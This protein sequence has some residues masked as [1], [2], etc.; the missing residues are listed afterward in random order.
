[1]PVY[2]DC[3][4]IINNYIENAKT[5]TKNYAKVIEEILKA[6]FSVNKT[7]NKGI[8]LTIKKPTK[9]FGKPPFPP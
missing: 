8:L 2:F 5:N 3:K 1:V 7:Y 6:T 4:K 9:S